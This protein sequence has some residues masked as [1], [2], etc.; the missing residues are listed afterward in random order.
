MPTVKIID[1]SELGSLSSNTST[2]ACK[3]APVNKPATGAAP[4]N[5]VSN[6]KP[7][8]LIINSICN[9]WTLPHILLKKV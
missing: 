2:N 9:L 8:I 4:G 3:W 5:E 7:F 6:G 1:F